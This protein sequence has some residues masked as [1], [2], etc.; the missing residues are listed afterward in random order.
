M[1]GELWIPESCVLSLSSK[2]SE[3]ELNDL[4]GRVNLDLYND[5]LFGKDVK[6]NMEITAK[7]STMEFADMKDIR[8]ELYNTTVE[9]GEIGN[10]IIVSKYSRFEAGNAGKVD[11]DAYNDKYS[12][13]AIGDIRFIDKYSDL[14]AHKAV[15]TELDCYSSTVSIGQAEDVDLKSKYGAYEF[16]EAR[17][18]NVSSSYSDKYEIDS[19]RSLNVTESKYGVY[20]IDY[21]DNSVLLS[22]GYSDKF[23]IDGSGKLKG[24]KLNGKYVVLELAIDKELSFVFRAD[25]K[26]PKF[27]IDE[28]SL[29]VRTKIKEGSELKME[30]YRGAEAR[31]MPAFFVNGYD[32]AVTLT[33]Q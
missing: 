28:E 31:D 23:L 25:V 20:R 7:Y 9:A 6:S 33:E 17:N 26:Y 21:L 14:T 18:L 27:E 8:A 19:L 11:I 16:E 22:E 10:L 32:M 30:A 29:D 15:H 4:I 2:Y 24:V 1:K 3:I 5:K 12:L 13:G